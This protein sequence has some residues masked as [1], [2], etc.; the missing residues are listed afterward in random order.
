MVKDKFTPTGFRLSPTRDLIPFLRRRNLRQT[1]PA[2]KPVYL[3]PAREGFMGD[4][5]SIMA[6]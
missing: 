1:R 2:A 4:H 3:S 5:L 6:A